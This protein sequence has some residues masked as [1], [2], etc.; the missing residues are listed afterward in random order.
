MSETLVITVGNESEVIEVGPMPGP[1]SVSTS[2]VST[3]TAGYVK[4]TGSLLT[5][6]S[7]LPATD[8]TGTIADGRLS[9]NVPLKDAASNAFTGNL[10]ASALTAN[11]LQ[12][13]SAGDL[14]LSVTS[15]NVAVSGGP[16]VVTELNTERIEH[17]DIIQIATTASEGAIEITTE[18]SESAVRINATASIEM[19]ATTEVTANIFFCPDLRGD[20]VGDPSATESD[21]Y[22]CI[23]SRD[24]STVRYIRL[25]W[26]PE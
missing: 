2:T 14:S 7:T 17:P 21:D 12:R 5:S 22:L 9:S 13:S 25:L 18:G 1:N 4:S 3:L 20:F 16:L 10:S 26:Q 19:I 6:T 8:L 11:S 15:G 24:G 23:K